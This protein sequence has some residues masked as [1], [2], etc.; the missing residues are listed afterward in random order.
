MLVKNKYNI[1]FLNSFKYIKDVDELSN[2]VYGLKNYTVEKIEEITK[3]SES[4]WLIKRINDYMVYTGKMVRSSFFYLFL[5]GLVYEVEDLDAEL[6]DK[7]F[8]LGAIFELAHSATLIH[9]DILD[10]AS[11]RRGKP[12]VHKKF[13]VDGAIIFGDILIISV[14]N[15]AYNIYP[16]Y[17]KILMEC[18]KDMCLGEVLQ[19]Q[20]KYN[21]EIE[22]EEYLKILFLKTGTLFGAISHIAYHLASEVSGK[23][24]KKEIALTLYDLFSRYGVSFQIVD[25]ILDYIQKSKILKKDSY[26]DLLSG[27]VTYPLIILARSKDKEVLRKWKRLWLNNPAYF[28]S[29][30][31][32]EMAE[33][34]KRYESLLDMARKFVDFETLDKIFKEVAFSNVFSR[35]IKNFVLSFVD[36]NY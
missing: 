30:I 4:N 2:F 25:D 20:N 8:E 22:E 7:V 3:F 16:C 29:L 23:E 33:N 5:L 24:Y 19:Y 34:F 27:R 1:D 12:S 6:W 35:T 28:L 21:F 10:N 32:R 18:L 11:T 31:K 17:S 15:E 9:D 26:S 36:R 14:L 13:G